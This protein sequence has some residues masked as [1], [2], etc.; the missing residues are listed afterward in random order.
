MQ[1]F[2]EEARKWIIEGGGPELDWPKLTLINDSP[3]ANIYM[4]PL[5]LDY[6]SFRPNPPNWHRFEAFVR[7]TKSQET[8]EIPTELQNK[9][10]NLVYFSIGTIGCGDLVVM[11]RLIGFLAKSPH[12]FIISKGEN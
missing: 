8:F 7:G 12:R 3:Y 11:K 6:I 2:Y 1:P 9:P 5:E 10:G 4:Y